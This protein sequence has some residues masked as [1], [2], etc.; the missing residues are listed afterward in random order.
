MLSDPEKRRAYD[1][2]GDSFHQNFNNN[3]SQDG[4]NFNDFFKNFDEAMKNH[5]QQHHKAHW[6]A[7]R[8]A[9]KKNGFSFDFDDIF[10]GF[11]FHDTLLNIHGGFDEVDQTG[12]ASYFE[13]S[14][15]KFKI[16]IKK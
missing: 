3:N 12:E 15:L 5:N 2:S 6:K 1:Q 4:F 11:N 7:H 9:M 8:E 10:E 16:H 13:E 14:N